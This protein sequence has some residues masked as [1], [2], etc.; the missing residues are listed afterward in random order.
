VRAATPVERLWLSLESRQPV[1][2]VQQSCVA[3]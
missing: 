2:Q 1:A 3:P